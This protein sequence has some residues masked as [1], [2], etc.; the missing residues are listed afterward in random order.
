MQICGRR[1]ARAGGVAART[2]TPPGAAF[3]AAAAGR[4]R[5]SRSAGGSPG[6]RAARTRGF[7]TRTPTRR[8]GRSRRTRRPPADSAHCTSSR[9]VGTLFGVRC[10]QNT[11]ESCVF[12]SGFQFGGFWLKL[13]TGVPRLIV[14]AGL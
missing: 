6:A 12:V 4:R 9:T 5:P 8:R 7:A 10:L 2:E 3:A 13:F 1:V 14:S 11:G